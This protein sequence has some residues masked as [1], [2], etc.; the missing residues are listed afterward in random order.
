MINCKSILLVLS[1]CTLLISCNTDNKK[2]DESELAYQDYRAFVTD[3]EQDTV[4]TESDLA[5]DWNSQTDS[6]RSTFDTHKNNITNHLTNYDAE[7]REEVNSFDE[8]LEVAFEDRQK[9][10]EDVSYRYKFRKE[11]L[12]MEVSEDDMSSIDASNIVATYEHFVNK[13]K[14]NQADYTKRDWEYLEGWW[15]GLQNRRQA[16][17]SKLKQEDLTRMNKLQETYQQ[18]RQQAITRLNATASNA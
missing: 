8:R 12:N 7:R 13:V 10:Y 1:F 16:V 2:V 3:I 11:M 17:S 18:L 9:R 5:Y 15:N 14:A 6:L 4:V